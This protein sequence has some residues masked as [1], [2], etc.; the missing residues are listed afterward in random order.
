MHLAKPQDGLNFKKP[1]RQEDTAKQEEKRTCVGAPK[2]EMP[3]P[4]F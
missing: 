4:A 2:G 1:K 3:N